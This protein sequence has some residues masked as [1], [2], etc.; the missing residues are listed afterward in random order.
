MN[1]QIWTQECRAKLEDY[2]QTHELP[3]GL[4]RKE[5]ACSIAAI[6]LAITGELTDDIPDC[7]SKVLGKATMALQDAMPDKMRNSDRYKAVLIDMPG[8][9]HN[10]EQRR[11]EVIM[12][13]MWDVVLPQLQDISDEEGFGKEWRHMC[14]QKSKQAADAAVYAARAARAVYAARAASAAYAV[15]YA[16]D[17]SASAAYTARAVVYAG[18]AARAAASAARA[19]YAASSAADFWVRVDPIGVLERM[20]YIDG[21]RT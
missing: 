13:W 2:L 16:A 11:M 9:G 20:T 12:A 8:T 1:N 18:S 17:A 7:M 14:E 4:G 6:N 10:R 5:S 15:V 3:S 21:D 19:V